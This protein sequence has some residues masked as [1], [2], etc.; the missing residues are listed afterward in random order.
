MTRVEVK[1]E[2]LQWARERA[3][4]SLARLRKRFPQI[5]AWEGGQAKPTLKQLEAFAKANFVPIGYLF[6]SEPPVEEIPIPDLRTI[7]SEGTKHPSPDLLDVIYLC[8]RR[9]R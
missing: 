7:G 9:L 3:G 5:D 8:Q 6:L 1:P 2:L 4:H